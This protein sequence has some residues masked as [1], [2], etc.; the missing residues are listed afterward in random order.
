MLAGSEFRDDTAVSR[1]QIDLRGNNIRKNLPAIL[2]DGGG[3]FVAGSLDSEN[4]HGAKRI[5]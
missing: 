3:S 4:Q 5:T 2:D 1:M